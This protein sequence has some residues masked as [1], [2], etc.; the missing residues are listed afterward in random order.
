[1][2][3][4]GIGKCYKYNIYILVAVLSQFVEEGL[5]GLN[6]SNKDNPGTIFSF[7]P[8]LK[9]HALFKNLIF[10]ISSFFAGII[11][12]F[13]NFRYAKNKEGEISISKVE[14]MQKELLGRKRQPI[15]LALFLTGFSLSINILIKSL[16]SL[17]YVH[18]GFW[19]LEVAYIS[20]FS[21]YILKINITKHKKVAIFI[22]TC[23]LIII[24]IFNFFFPNTK[25][26]CEIPGECNELTDTNTFK[27]IKIRF[28]FWYIPLLFITYEIITSMRDYSWVKS[29]YLMD[30]R[31]FAPFKILFA[32]GIIGSVLSIILYSIFTAFPCNSFNNVTINEKNNYINMDNGE[33]IN[34]LYEL[35]T[36]KYYDKNTNILYL[37]YDSFSVFLN[38]YKERNTDTFIEIFIIIPLYFLMCLIN[39]FS[40]IMMI[41]YSDPNNILI[42]K[43]FYHFLKRIIVLILNKADEKYLTIHNFIILEIQELLSII[44]NMIYIEIIELRFL[45]LDYELKKNIKKRGETEVE[46][47]MTDG[48]N[49]RTESEVME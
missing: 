7:K 43:N 42:S 27:Y 39:I 44:S 1:M 3:F 21:L 17:F 46:L 34:F 11:A 19:M 33:E 48:E 30:I 31:S 24:E 36:L 18:V 2:S 29:K 45:G 47:G 49:I 4:I 5:L 25:H 40:H 28:G 12:F 9:N 16:F 6:S 20:I 13:I 23:P 35:C 37:Y 26:N 32:I 41:R 22:M 38:N 10:F 15:L 14:K 8:K